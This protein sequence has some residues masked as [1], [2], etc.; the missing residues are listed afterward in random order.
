MGLAKFGTNGFDGV[1]V[2]L[3]LSLCC[4]G[5]RA[6]MGDDE[7]D[8]VLV[9]MAKKDN[10]F[11]VIIKYSAPQVTSSAALNFQDNLNNPM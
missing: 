8:D 3:V 5:D 2:K 7:F 9:V 11:K 4:L 1:K 10:S 6:L